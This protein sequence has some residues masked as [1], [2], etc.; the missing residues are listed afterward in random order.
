MRHLPF[1]AALLL[2][3]M[4]A[5]A[6]EPPAVPPEVQAIFPL[7]ADS[8]Y[9]A[10][11]AKPEL[12][13]NQKLTE[14]YLYRLYDPNPQLEEIQLPRDKAIAY[15]SRPETANWTDLAARFN[16]KPY[17]YTQSLSCW[18]S[19][20]TDRQVSC[21]VDCDGGSFK[22]DADGA[23]LKARFGADGGLSLNQSCG[24]PDEEGYDRWMT[25]A[26]AGGTVKLEKFPVADCLKLDRAARPAFAADPVPLRERIATLGWRCLNRSYDKAHLAKHPK[27][28]VTNISV[29]ISGQATSSQANDGE[30][31][32][33]SLDVTLSFKLR[34]GEVKSR[35]VQCQASQYEFAC[36]GGFR[37]RRR[38]SNSALLAAGEYT[39]A[40]KPPSMLDTVLGSDDT[41]FRLDA[42]THDDCSIE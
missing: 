36:D 14:F 9:A 33:T 12:K 13:P 15:F 39:E 38:D 22:L 31:P 11:M 10:H 7:D 27:Q 5:V 24:E 17:L 21:G 29:A 30:Y 32:S 2:G 6:Q 4:P 40:G 42:E 37:L 23:G 8:C 41:L 28:K 35:D 3:A 34:N 20:E 16:D 26:E 18:V 19:G 1:T 25:S